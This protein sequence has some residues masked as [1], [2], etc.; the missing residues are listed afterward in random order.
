[1]TQWRGMGPPGSK[2]P[3]PRHGLVG[4]MPQLEYFGPGLG[5][6]D[7]RGRG[8]TRGLIDKYLGDEDRRDS[9]D[10]WAN[11]AGKKVYLVARVE[12]AEAM[13]EFQ[14]DFLASARRRKLPRR[15]VNSVIARC[16]HEAGSN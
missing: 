8:W 12:A 6:D 9:V 14:M 7:L 4:A 3:E 2:P 13:P 1:M 11:F 16:R 15:F 10:H 5:M